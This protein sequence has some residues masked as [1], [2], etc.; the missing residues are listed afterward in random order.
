MFHSMCGQQRVVSCFPSCQ[1]GA[2]IDSPDGRHLKTGVT[3]S[4]NMNYVQRARS[5]SLMHAEIKENVRR[6]CGSRTFTITAHTYTRTTRV[7][8]KFTCTRVSNFHLVRSSTNKIK[9]LQSIICI[10]ILSQSIYPIQFLH[11]IQSM[12]THKASFDHRKL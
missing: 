4:G 8:I 7:E 11:C 5:V 9:N 12:V 10:D 3:R 2:G 6:A 1:F